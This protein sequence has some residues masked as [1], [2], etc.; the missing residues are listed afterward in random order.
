MIDHHLFL[1]KCH[2]TTKLTPS[3]RSIPAYEVA[4]SRTYHGTRH[5]VA[6]STTKLR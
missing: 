3:L 5:M 6:A 1:T 2:I 4:M